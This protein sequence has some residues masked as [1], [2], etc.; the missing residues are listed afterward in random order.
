MFASVLTEW[1]DLR[2]R[3]PSPS[4]VAVYL[5]MTRSV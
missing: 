4:T 2:E 5:Q 1:I 3:T